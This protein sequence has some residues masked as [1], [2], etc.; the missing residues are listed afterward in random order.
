MSEIKEIF[1]N[2]FWQNTACHNL[3]LLSK[4]EL[5]DTKIIEIEDNSA[6]VSLPRIIISNIE[7]KEDFTHEKIRIRNENINIV[8]EN[9]LNSKIEFYT[10]L[11]TDFLE[12]KFGKSLE[13]VINDFNNDPWKLIGKAVTPVDREDNFE[14]IIIGFLQEYGFIGKHIN[15]F[16]DLAY[17]FQKEAISKNVK[18]ILTEKNIWNF[19]E[20]L[21]GI[22]DIYVNESYRSLYNSNQILVNALNNTENLYSRLQLFSLLFESGIIYP[23]NE[24]SFIECTNCE[25]GTYRG[26]FQLKINPKKLKELKCPICSSELTYYV[27][28]KL[29]KEIYNIIKL[30]DGLLHDALCNLLT[31]NK[32][33]FKTNQKYLNDIELDCV[34]KLDEAIHVVECKM[35]KIN[36]TRE[37]LNS[38]V[39]E[40]FSKLVSDISRIRESAKWSKEN[41]RPILLV[42]IIDSVFL[43]GIETELK[44]KNKDEIS[45]QTRII[46]LTQLKFNENTK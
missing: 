35:Y 25:P 32:I 41:I 21:K 17:H 8:T 2:L 33:E 14:K 19:I 23:G 30:Q 9:I 34:Y 27:P 40:D 43:T 31:T 28:Y 6:S 12:G 22:K 46:N 39:K 15:S 37:K 26:V 38:K 13:K 36:T 16:D 7:S 3:F 4:E 1:Y 44:E 11:I 45:Q 24:D 10:P 20:F 5:L 42:N 18:T 29:H